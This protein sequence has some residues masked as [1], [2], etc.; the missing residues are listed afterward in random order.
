MLTYQEAKNYLKDKGLKTKEE[1]DNF[2]NKNRK[3]C[4]RIG[5]PKNPDEYYGRKSH[6]HGIVDEVELQ[7]EVEKIQRE[8]TEEIKQEYNKK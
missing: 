2:W 8:W 5:L 1:Y 7:N 6:N 4:I 3:E